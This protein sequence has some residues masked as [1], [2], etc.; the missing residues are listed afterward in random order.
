MRR[1]AALAMAAALFAWGHNGAAQE[2]VRFPSLE[3]NGADRAATQ[4]DGY[5]YRPAGEERRPAVVFLHGC[6]GL[7]DRNSG[8]VNKR[9]RAW[10]EEL[11]RR[12]YAVL[13]VD[14]FR[15]RNIGEMCS[16]A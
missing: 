12:G 4:L 13:M 14:S 2:L 3:D 7:I 16:P 5:L 6:G 8:W 10:A 1:L 9:E 11:T 15:P